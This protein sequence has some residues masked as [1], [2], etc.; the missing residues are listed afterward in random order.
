MVRFVSQEI[1]GQYE[2]LRAQFPNAE[3][4]ASTLEQFVQ[5][6][7]PIRGRLPNISA[8]IGDTWIQGIQSDPR[9]VWEMKSFL[10]HRSQCLK[11]GKFF[12]DLSSS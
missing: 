10:R 6:V 9:K 8:E 4:R 1:L 11:T 7:Y 2:I 3:L 12:T 5:A